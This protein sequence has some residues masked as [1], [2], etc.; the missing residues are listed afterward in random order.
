[1][2]AIQGRNADTGTRKH[3]CGSANNQKTTATVIA[4]ILSRREAH[5]LVENPKLTTAVIRAN[6]ECLA[7]LGSQVGPQEILAACDRSGVSH[8]GYASIYKT[9]KHSL[10]S[11]NP[12]LSFKCL[13]NPHK[14]GTNNLACSVNS[15]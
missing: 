7:S 2:K 5:V 6:N 10:R 11:V 1:M 14:V 15:L 9:M 8:K 3:I 4:S 12:K 13:P